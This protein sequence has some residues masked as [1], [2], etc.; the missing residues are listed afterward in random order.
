MIMEKLT[1]KE[2]ELLIE[3]I[4]KEKESIHTKA[5]QDKELREREIEL[6]FISIKLNTQLKQIEG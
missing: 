5:I 4:Q 2:L 3:L 6:D 1:R